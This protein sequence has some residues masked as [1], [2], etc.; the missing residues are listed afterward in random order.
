[1]SKELFNKGVNQLRILIDNEL[2]EMDDKYKDEYICPGTTCRFSEDNINELSLE[3]A[4]QNALGGQKIALTSKSWNNECGREVD[5]YLFN[6]IVNYENAHFVPGS[7]SKVKIKIKDKEFNGMLMVHL[8][9][10]MEMRN[11]EKQNDP[12][13][14]AEYMSQLKPGLKYSI[15]HMPSKTDINRASAAILKNAYIILFS[16][17]GYTFLLDDYYSKIREQI[18]KPTEKILPIL[19]SMNNP[20]SLKDGVYFMF[21][22]CEK[23]FLVVYTIKRLL[24]YQVLV[25]IPIPSVSYD[26]MRSYLDSLNSGDKMTLSR[27]CEKDVYWSDINYIKGVS[28][29]VFQ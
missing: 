3:D 10:K 17:F 27:I 8:D 20:L 16:K 2:I 4:P 29:F 21:P 14:L 13:L 5:V 22:P 9:G 1:M 23:G 12:K 18:E 28:D 15:R 24:E 26:K 11:S 6:S 7:A 25:T 19:W